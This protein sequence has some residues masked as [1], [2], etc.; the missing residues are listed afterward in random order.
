[1]KTFDIELPAAAKVVFPDRCVVCE[2]AAPDD[3]VKLSILGAESPSV[4]TFVIDRAIGADLDP[5]YYGSNTSNEIAGIPACR[6]CSSGLRW[7][8]R[9]LKIGYYTAWI[10]GLLPIL[11]LN[12]PTIFNVVF[13]LVCATSPGIFTLIFPPSFGATF[14]GDKANFEFKSKA[15]AEEFLQLNAEARLKGT[16][17]AD[18]A[19]AA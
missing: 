3:F 14:Y 18:T 15:V 8:H 11:L 5:K 7:Y 4:S 6:K 9:L 10:P 19:I 2:A 1:M 17:G 12:T 13:L 16:D